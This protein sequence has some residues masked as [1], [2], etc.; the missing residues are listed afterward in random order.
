MNIC[1]GIISYLPDDQE[2]RKHRAEQLNKLLGQ[3][4]TMFKL[5]IIIIAQN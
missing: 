1:I 3:C 5:P 4:D 2:I